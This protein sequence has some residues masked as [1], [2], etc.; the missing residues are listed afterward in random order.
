[1]KQQQQYVTKLVTIH[2]TPGCVA[3]CKDPSKCLL[4][5]QLKIQG[6]HAPK[7]RADKS[8][9]KVPL[10]HPRA[11]ELGVGTYVFHTPRPISYFIGG[12]DATVRGMQEGEITDEY[13]FS[14]SLDDPDLFIEFRPENRLT[15]EQKA[16]KALLRATGRAP[17]NHKRTAPVETLERQRRGLYQ[18]AV[19][20]PAN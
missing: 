11:A 5:E 15:P 18:K 1:V 6:F 16:H 17:R 4:A 9:F 10:G 12:Y 8:Q 7:I 20:R 19:G 13:L 2:I 14:F 3:V